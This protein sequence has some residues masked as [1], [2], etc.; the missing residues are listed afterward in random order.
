MGRKRRIQFGLLD[1][2]LRSRGTRPPELERDAGLVREV[3][4]FYDHNGR[5]PNEDSSDHDE[6]RLGTIWNALAG[7]A[8]R[9]LFAD[10]DR[11]RLLAEAPVAITP[12]MRDWRDE[13]LEDEIP[14]SLDDIFAEEDDDVSE[15]FTQIRNVTPVV[16][17]LLPDHR[18]EFFPCPDF[19][20]FRPAFEEL[21]AELE[22]GAREATAET[23]RVADLFR[24]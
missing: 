15:A 22:A 18:A 21:Q 6:M 1:V 5:L 11:N 19:E 16:D 9:E 10:V 12:P 3:N 23:D 24:R 7:R 2:Q 8:D 17:R 14:D 4:D 13:P 20:T